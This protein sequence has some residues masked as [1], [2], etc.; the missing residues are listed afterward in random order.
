MLPEHHSLIIEDDFENEFVYLQ[1]PTPS[2]FSLA[3]G[4]DVVY[5]GSFSRLL[6]P[7]IR[8]SFMVLPPSLTDV[9]RQKRQTITRLL[10]RQ[11]RL[12]SA[13][14]SG[15]DIWQRRRG[16][17]RRLYSQKLE[18]AHQSSE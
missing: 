9:Y 6:L 2:L 8:I 7:S 12:H 16:K 1:K 15:M 17:L 3:G 14:L 11:S 10:P 13:S 18:A 5:I 4:Q